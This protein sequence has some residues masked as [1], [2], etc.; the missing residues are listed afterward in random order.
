M[1]VFLPASLVCINT[2]FEKKKKKERRGNQQ[3]KKKWSVYNGM[4][5]PADVRRYCAN[6]IVTPE[7]A[8]EWWTAEACAEGERLAKYHRTM[9]RLFVD[10]EKKE[11]PKKKKST[12]SRSVSWSSGGS[13]GGGSEDDEEEEEKKK[14]KE[15]DIE[16]YVRELKKAIQHPTYCG[17]TRVLKYMCDHASAPAHLAVLVVN[18]HKRLHPFV[19]APPALHKTLDRYITSSSSQPTRDTRRKRIR[20]KGT[21]RTQKEEEHHNSRYSFG[22]LYHTVVPTEDKKA[23]DYHW[24]VLQT[25]SD[26]LFPLSHPLLIHLIRRDIVDEIHPASLS[27]PLQSN[28][29]SIRKK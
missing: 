11:K 4:E 13:R 28:I 29:T 15:N 25:H 22:I 14:K 8:Y 20:R 24:Q 19:F 10:K 17:T 18:R 12:G 2:Q 26:V 9:P 16:W 23:F 7:N 6:V 21:Q 1:I 27:I 3:K 5:T